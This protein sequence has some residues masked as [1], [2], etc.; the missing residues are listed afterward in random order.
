MGSPDILESKVQ[1]NQPPI[2]IGSNTSGVDWDGKDPDLQLLVSMGWVDFDYAETMGI[3]LVEGRSF[4]KSFS[5]DTSSAYM[6][7]EELVRRMG[8][9]SAVNKRFKMGDEG[10]IIG[11]MKDYHFLS[12]QQSIEPLAIRVTTDRINYLV[13]RLSVGDI[14][15]KIDF[16]KS[17]WNRVSF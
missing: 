9:E 6:V 12:L 2:H 11:V 8:F 10:V 15:A 16:V 7:N 14:P 4:S 17:I 1:T 13:V 3:K 5:T